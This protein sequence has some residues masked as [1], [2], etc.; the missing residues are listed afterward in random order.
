MKKIVSVDFFGASVCFPVENLLPHCVLWWEEA[1]K[2]V[3]I[4]TSRSRGLIIAAD[5]RRKGSSQVSPLRAASGG[6]ECISQLQL[7]KLT[8]GRTL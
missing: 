6:E 5:V 8:R 2:K 4:L 1:G 3:W 7:G